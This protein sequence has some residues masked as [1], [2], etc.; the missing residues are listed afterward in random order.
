[1]LPVPEVM[2]NV[3]VPQFDEIRDN[4]VSSIWIAPACPVPI[5]ILADPF[6]NG[7]MVNVPVP[8]SAAPMLISPAELNERLFAPMVCAP[9]TKIVPVPVR[10]RMGSVH[11]LAPM[12]R[13]AVVLVD[14]MTTLFQFPIIRLS[15]VSLS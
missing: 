4:S 14:P 12:F 11:V 7:E 5:P 10:N 15:S 6:V 2:P 13:S 3:I 9:L 8:S 1:M